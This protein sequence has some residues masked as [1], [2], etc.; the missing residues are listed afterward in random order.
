MNNHNVIITF[1]VGMLLG[2]VG[3]H[4]FGSSD[5]NSTALLS[6]AVE[7]IISFAITIYLL[8]FGLLMYGLYRVI[9]WCKKE[10]STKK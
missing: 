9:R 10:D 2:A 1:L 8:A 5:T 7:L 4:F 3:F 6:K